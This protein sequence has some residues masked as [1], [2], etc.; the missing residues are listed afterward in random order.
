MNGR[1]VSLIMESVLSR[2]IHNAVLVFHVIALRN[3]TVNL[4]E[5]EIKQNLLDQGKLNNILIVLCRCGN[6]H[7]KDDTNKFLLRVSS[8]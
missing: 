8:K 3:A 4:F 1:I 5:E 6:E 2:L 7:I